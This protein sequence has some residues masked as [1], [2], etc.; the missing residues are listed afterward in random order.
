[1]ID[2]LNDLETQRSAQIADMHGD[3]ETLRVDFTSGIESELVAM[4]INTAQGMGPP[5]RRNVRELLPWVVASA[6]ASA[7]LTWAA[8]TMAQL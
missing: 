2:R 6:V 7:G 4:G 1:M 8:V 3:L 5:A